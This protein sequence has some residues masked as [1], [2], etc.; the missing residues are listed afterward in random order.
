MRRRRGRSEPPLP[1]LA[2]LGP[3]G[4]GKSTVIA[5]VREE[6]PPGMGSVVTYHWRP[7]AL[8][9]RA[10]T[11]DPVTDPHGQPPRRPVVSVLKLVWLLANWW[12]GWP[13][14][15]A[16]RS[17]G[18]LVVFDRHYLDL[19]V[20]PRRYRYGGPMSAARYVARMVPRPDLVFI[21]DAPA[22]T[23]QSRKSE[24]P[25]AETERQRAAY[26]ALARRLPSAVVL[27][28]GGSPDETAEA[29]VAAVRRWTG[30]RGS[31]AR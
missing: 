25:M 29:I 6:F 19:L 31:R 15:A 28:A 27:D 11:T 14:I 12:A 30:E 17:K 26:G 1:W 10:A 22:E 23:L 13:A 21:L 9:R 3:D 18:H 24:V 16:Q 7:R 4:S 2:V 5:R 20:D 8:D